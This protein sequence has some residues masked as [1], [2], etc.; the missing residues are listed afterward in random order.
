MHDSATAFRAGVPSTG[1]ALPL[2]NTS[3]PVASHLAMG[4]GDESLEQLIS[5]VANGIFVTRFWYIR[6]VHLR[7]TI[8]TGMTREGTFRIRDGKLAGPIRDLRLTQ[9]IVEALAD[10][11]GIG[12]ERRLTLGDDDAAI[13]VPAL[14]LGSFTFSS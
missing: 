6:P 1:H 7:R 5:G 10:V 13:L 14:R 12:R 11:R 4:A 8:I 3:G 2:P 9:S